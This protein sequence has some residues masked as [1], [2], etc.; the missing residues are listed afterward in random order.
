MLDMLKWRGSMKDSHWSSKLWVGHET[1]QDIKKPNGG[2]W[3]HIRRKGI[4][5]N[6]GKDSKK[7]TGPSTSEGL[8]SF[9]L[10]KETNK[11]WD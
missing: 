11:L 8:T 2:G 10:H 1:I 6:V 5:H 9:W 7:T 4:C 3:K